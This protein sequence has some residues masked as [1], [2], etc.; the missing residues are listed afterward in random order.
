MFHFFLSILVHVFLS[1]VLTMFVLPMMAV[2]VIILVVFMLLLKRRA[3][4]ITNETLRWDAITRSPLN[5]L[6][7]ATLHGL[8]TVR[9]FARQPHFR[10]RFLA[11]TDE[12][13]R[14]FF[15]F[16]AVS[17]WLGMRLDMLAFSY[18]SLNAFLAVILKSSFDLPISPSL[19]GM[20]L[21]I[22]V[23]LGCTF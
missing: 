23:E 20:S 6:F 1:V 15:T 4:F 19:L 13:A 11:L 17:R 14:A 16:I 22:S 3:T 8:A 12:N 9:A 5:S 2:V 21:A 18:I 7:A 10:A